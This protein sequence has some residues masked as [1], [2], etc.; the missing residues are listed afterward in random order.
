MLGRSRSPEALPALIKAL[1]DSSPDVRQQAA[2]ALGQLRLNLRDLAARSQELASFAG[3]SITLIHT[4]Q[5]AFGR[6]SDQTAG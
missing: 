5:A 3:T 4:L 1:K 6:G 2:F